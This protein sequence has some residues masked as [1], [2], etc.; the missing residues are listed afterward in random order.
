MRNTH[1]LLLIVQCFCMTAFANINEIDYNKIPGCE[2]FVGHYYYVNDNQRYFARWSP[3]WN[4]DVKKEDVIGKLKEAYAAFLLLPSPNVERSLLLGD[5]AHYLYNLDVQNYSDSAVYHY[6]R[7]IEQAPLDCRGH[8]F[9]GF[10]YALAAL[11]PKAVPL[12]LTAEKLLPETQ[13]ADFWEE[14][15]ESMS[16]VNMPSHAIFAMEKVKSITGTTGFFDKAVGS[17]IRKRM[18]PMDKEKSYNSNQIWFSTAHNDAFVPFVSRPLGIKM[19]VDSA[20]QLSFYNYS[21]HQT[22]VMCTPYPITNTKGRP[23]SYSIAI[24]MKVAG[25]QDKLEDYVGSML[26]HYTNKT[27]IPFSNRYDGMVTYEIKEPS[28]YPEWGGGHMYAVTFERRM[29]SFPGLLLESPSYPPKGNAGEMAYYKALPSQN[30]FEGR[31]F[32]VILLDACEDI[33]EKAQSV[34][35]TFYEQHLVIE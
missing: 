26:N 18:T 31:I 12:L 19:E 16:L 20:W 25:E 32:Y 9:L 1:L 23:I 30:R 28:M 10:H 11:L 33:A 34:F 5:V 6:S 3:T 7:A 22:A 8:W 13:P 17:A 35:K 14:Y 2:Q 27:I 21:K 15:A 24:L 29:P 4:F